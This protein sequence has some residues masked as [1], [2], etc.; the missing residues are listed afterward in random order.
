MNKFQDI[1]MMSLF[2]ISLLFATVFFGI[3]L[4]AY[5]LETHATVVSKVV[6]QLTEELKQ[7]KCTNE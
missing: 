7:D 2:Y 4:Y 1:A 5:H 3:K 6:V